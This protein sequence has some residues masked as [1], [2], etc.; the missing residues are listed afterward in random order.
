MET[1][2]EIAGILTGMGWFSWVFVGS[3]FF[4]TAYIIIY[5]NCMHEKYWTK[6]SLEDLEEKGRLLR[7]VRTYKRNEQRNPRVNGY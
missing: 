5:D 4:V 6:E 2:V 1:L 3:V 7:E